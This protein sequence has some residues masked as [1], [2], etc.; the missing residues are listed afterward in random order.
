MTKEV[1]GKPKM[2]TEKIRPLE[3][4]WI[5]KNPSGQV[6]LDLNEKGGETMVGHVK[7][8]TEFKICSKSSKVSHGI[9]QQAE[10]ERPEQ[11]L[12]NW[13]RIH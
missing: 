3:W 9:R 5:A 12:K 11:F 13:H 10:S 6:R 1:K 2:R 8:R 7:E 4:H